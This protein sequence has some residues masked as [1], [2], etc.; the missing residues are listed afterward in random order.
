MDTTHTKGTSIMEN[1]VPTHNLLP[2]HHI[3]KG[4]LVI[5]HHSNNKLCSQAIESLSLQ[6]MESIESFLKKSDKS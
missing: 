3:I 2:I 1:Y 4:H 6:I 5:F